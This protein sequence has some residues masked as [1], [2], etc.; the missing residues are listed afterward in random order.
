MN[1][2]KLPKKSQN[3]QKA[4]LNATVTR[5]FLARPILTEDLGEGVEWGCSVTP[6]Y[7]PGQRRGDD[8]EAK[9]LEAP[10]SSKDIV[11]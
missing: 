2:A 9:L 4:V 6:P 8:K 11:L 10:I 5:D 3:I 7:G 1:Q